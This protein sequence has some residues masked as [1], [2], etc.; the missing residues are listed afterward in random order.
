M[1]SRSSK[2]HGL[3]GDSGGQ[4][5]QHRGRDN[6]QHN[7][8][9]LGILASADSRSLRS[10]S[11][12]KRN[13]QQQSSPQLRSDNW[14]SQQPSFPEKSKS[15]LAPNSCLAGQ[16]GCLG[17]L[18]HHTYIHTYTHALLPPWLSLAPWPPCPGLPVTILRP[19]GP[20]SDRLLYLFL[21]KPSSSPQP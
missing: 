16:E 1:F 7:L 9:E 15:S 5:Q 19:H 14:D 13:K 2:S 3:A 21:Q 12:F 20:I 6:F 17:A 18:V 8:R 10:L 4:D 11:S